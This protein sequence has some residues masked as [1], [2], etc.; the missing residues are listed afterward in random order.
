MNVRGCVVNTKK[1][2]MAKLNLYYLLCCLFL[3]L[4]LMICCLSNELLK[5][6]LSSMS[7][8]LHKT[9]DRSWYDEMV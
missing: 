1:R 3:L 4:W 2:I 5:E 8:E 7:N 9:K 6:N